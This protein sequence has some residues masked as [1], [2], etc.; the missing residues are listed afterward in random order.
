MFTLQQVAQ[1]RTY[2]LDLLTESEAAIKNPRALPKSREAARRIAGMLACAIEELE[3]IL[4]MRDFTTV[5]LAD[6]LSR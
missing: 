6:G 4:G 5:D 3:L 2:L 1:R